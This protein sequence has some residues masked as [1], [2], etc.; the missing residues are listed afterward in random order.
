L[1]R[2]SDAIDVSFFA[3]ITG[4]LRTCCHIGW[5]PLD[6]T[7]YEQVFVAGIWR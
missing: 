6:L 7:Y 2:S 3:V 5:S 1:V 4:T